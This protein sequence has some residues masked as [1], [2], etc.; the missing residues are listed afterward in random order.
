MNPTKK[1][2]YNATFRLRKKIGKASVKTD[3]KTIFA[4]IEDDLE[5]QS[6]VKILLMEFSYVIQTGI[7]TKI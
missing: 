6:E 5:N 7:F 2:K 1:R 4:D 3:E